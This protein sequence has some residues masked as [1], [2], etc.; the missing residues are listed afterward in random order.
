MNVYNTTFRDYSWKGDTDIR[1]MGSST[2]VPV[3]S[4]IAGR[5][6]RVQL[7]G[8]GQ[9]SLAEVDVAAGEPDGPN[10]LSTDT[11][12][13]GGFETG[14]LSPWTTTGSASAITSPAVSGS[15][16]VQ[17]GA[18]TFLAQTITVKP[19]TTYTLSGYI[20]PQNTGNGVEL[21]VENYGGSYTTSYTSSAGW[22]LASLTFTTGSTNT[23][24][25]IFAYH[26]VGTGLAYADDVTCRPAA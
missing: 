21:G 17:L 20:E 6:V 15:D 19:N 10:M 2:D 14:S 23:T 24:A 4:G 8:T 11:V 16:A 26:D 7:A 13:N 12:A 1:A 3:S 18:S 25:E 5:Y 9:L 22:T